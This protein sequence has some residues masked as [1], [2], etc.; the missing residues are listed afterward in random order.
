MDSV[1]FYPLAFL[2]IWRTDLVFEVLV[3]VKVIYGLFGPAAA[4]ETF[5]IEDQRN[6]MDVE[7]HA[8]QAKVVGILAVKEDIPGIT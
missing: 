2:G 1:I 4:M 8:E 6:L 3:S 7:V 5:F